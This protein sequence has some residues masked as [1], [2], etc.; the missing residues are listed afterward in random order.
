MIVSD[1]TTITRQS[2]LVEVLCLPCHQH[3]NTHNRDYN[4]GNHPDTDN[5]T[6]QIDLRCQSNELKLI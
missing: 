5:H 6:P 2:I 1:T 3:R 4:D